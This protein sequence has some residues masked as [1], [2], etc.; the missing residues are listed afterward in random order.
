MALVNDGEVPAPEPTVARSHRVRFLVPLAT[1]G[2]AFAAYAATA[3]RTITWWDG[4]SYPLAAVTL[5]IPGSPG[6]LLLTLLGFVATRLV[7]FHPVAFQLD[8]CAGL[9]AAGLVGT[10][11][12]LAIEL[13]TP[14]GRAAGPIEALAGV[15][16][17]LVFAFSPTVWGYAVQFTPYI[18]TAWFTA[19]ILIVA[20]VWWR[21]ARISA[22]IGWLFVL[23]LLFGLDFS[24][25]RTNLLL[26]PGALAWVALRRPELLRH[27]RTWA[28]IAGGF[29]L[30]LAFH[31]LLIPIAALD[32]AYNIGDPSTLAR[33][34]TYVSI[35]DRGGAFLIDL[36]PRKADLV[37]VQLADYLTFLRMNLLD[38]GPG[39]LCVVP[40]ALV[41]IGAVAEWRAAPR[42]A[43]ALL[44]FFVCGSVGAIL[45]FNLPAH[46][47]RSV[48]RHYLP[49][50]V[51]LGP[52][53]GVGA[54][55]LLRVAARSRGALRPAL[56]FAF[57]LLV[58]LAP[59]G[60]WR[61]QHARCD[62]SRVR[63]AETL[64]RDFLEPLPHGAILFT[65]GDN[66]SFPLWYLQQ[67]EGVRRDVSVLNLPCLN[68]RWYRAT[69]RRHDASLAPLM[70]EESVMPRDPHAMPPDSSMVFAV[71]R[72]ASLGLPAGWVRP[73]SIALRLTA[74][75]WPE[76]HVVAE[77]VRR[78]RWRRP[79]YFATT[80]T[81]DHTPWL[82]PCAR[83]EGLA[84]R[85][86]PSTNMEAWD[87]EALRRTALEVLR[88]RDI[89]DSTIAIDSDSQ[90]L[91][92]NY[93]AAL[94]VLAGTQLSHGDARACLATLDFLDRHVPLAR[95]GHSEDPFAPVRAA[96][97]AQLEATS[98]PR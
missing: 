66:D 37:H 80:V 54:A 56:G 63:F 5:G 64:A 75:T 88:Y 18:L 10:V 94:G 16:A 19:L 6:S 35:N 93:V 85:I 25:H 7:F 69:L 9:I 78:N 4:S 92:G 59:I 86:V 97:H 74:E 17:G 83:L 95:L 31:L 32:P 27:A 49:S 3:C 48:F 39:A 11:S 26:M 58:A 36:F 14:E 29:V 65:N 40:A 62:L 53:L 21:R 71:D 89:A 57:G 82:W 12:W 90:A 42:R 44:A 76:D 72:D 43:L 84:Y 24:V 60:Q 47:F 1:A 91:A 8:L 15:A 98:R 34:W 70:I 41:V 67:V 52:L 33:F 22:A 61:A 87:I 55:A 50:L 96:A 13:A 51:I 45:Y 28:A 77:M 79:M 68:T 20:T 38:A 46:Y 81:R 73:D 23:F 30:G 2:V